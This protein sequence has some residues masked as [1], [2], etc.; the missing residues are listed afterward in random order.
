MGLLKTYVLVLIAGW[1]LWF[2]MDKP[3]VEQSYQPVSPYGA[4]P[5]AAP[6]PGY[7]PGAG[8]GRRPPAPPAGQGDDLVQT[9][10][11]SV[12]LI[13]AGAYRQSFYY[14]WRRQSWVLAGV[15]TLLFAL[16]L[17]G[18]GRSVRRWQ[19]ARQRQP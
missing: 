1:V 19:G 12:D 7:A 17:P 8:A 11:Y 18:L 6:Y 16:L 13:K 2:W 4:G 3:G 10:Q 15:I 9:F 14:L 5:A